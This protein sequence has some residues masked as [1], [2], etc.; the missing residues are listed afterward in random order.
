MVDSGLTVSKTLPQP[1]QQS[2]VVIIIMTKYERKVIGF[3]LRLP[4]SNGETG[5]HY[6][7][8]DP[9]VGVRKSDSGTS[10]IKEFGN[11]IKNL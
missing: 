1:S 4:V 6:Q 11:Y 7:T 8:S 10:D 2:K 5:T 3:K 9:P